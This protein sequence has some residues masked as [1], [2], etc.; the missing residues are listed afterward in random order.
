V[1]V[2]FRWVMCRKER[3]CKEQRHLIKLKREKMMMSIDDLETGID[4]ESCI[5]HIESVMGSVIAF[6]F[7][8]NWAIQIASYFLFLREIVGMM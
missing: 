5:S 4:N 6:F 7:I 8:S 1:E 3:S 2:T